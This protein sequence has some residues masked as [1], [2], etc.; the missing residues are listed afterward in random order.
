MAKHPTAVAGRVL[1]L[2]TV[3]HSWETDD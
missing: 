3:E 2:P 1:I